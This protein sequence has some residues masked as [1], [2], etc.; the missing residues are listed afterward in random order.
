MK[1]ILLFAV[2]S[3]ALLGFA[4]SCATPAADTGGSRDLSLGTVY[5]A[6]IIT[7][8]Y[9]GEA[10]KVI[11]A[12]SFSD[13]APEDENWALDWNGEFFELAVELP[14]GEYYYKYVVD[15]VWQAPKANLEKMDPIPTDFAGD[16]FGGNNAM[17]EV[18]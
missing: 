2:I 9:Y 4:V 5:E 11:L 3:I 12:G 18:E 7:F 17:I 6:G 16:G 13:W 8:R 10:D 14:A 15:G 1:K